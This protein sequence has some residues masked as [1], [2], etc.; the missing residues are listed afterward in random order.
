M[1][2]AVLPYYA[3]VWAMR[4]KTERATTESRRSVAR[5]ELFVE[6]LRANS[7]KTLRRF[8]S[9]SS[10]LRELINRPENATCCRNCMMQCLLYRSCGTDPH[11]TRA[12]VY[13]LCSRVKRST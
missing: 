12:E 5:L 11:V 6:S 8:V 10:F 3:Q 2:G 9:Y 1:R 4:I 13:Q 7:N